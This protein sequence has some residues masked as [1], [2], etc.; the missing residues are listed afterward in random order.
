MKLALPW[1]VAICAALCTRATCEI[2]P[3]ASPAGATPSATGAVIS[4]E[5]ISSVARDRT[6]IT[7]RAT[8]ADWTSWVPPRTEPAVVMQVVSKGFVDV[9]RNFIRL[10]ELNSAFTRQNMYLTCLD[11]ASVEMFASLGI[12]C[13]PL[14]ALQ[15]SSEHDIWRTR[16]RVVSC[17]V[18]AG[19]DVVMS[20]ADALWLSDP[21]EYMNLPA[22]R[23]S[24]V[25]ASRGNFPHNLERLWGTTICMGF[26]LFRATGAAM[27]IFQDRMERL[28]LMT[29]DDQI[30][31]NRAALELGISWD[32][33]SD[34][35]LEKSTGVGKGTIAKLSGDQGPF[36]VI[37]LPHNKFTRFC[38]STPISSET[39]VAHCHSSKKQSLGRRVSWMLEKKLWS[40]D[41]GDP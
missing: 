21:M 6:A 14:G 8:C 13:V 22:H 18:V 41:V 11:S 39:V 38:T 20:D 32:A 34:M 19:Y 25:I 16:V 10:M 15:M 2:P 26:I 24:S 17:L 37:L 31:A 36:E 30:S 1:S 33:D 7:K 27:Q 5:A 35:R 4:V 40:I 3:E 9:E 29:G 12:R 23:N 28:V